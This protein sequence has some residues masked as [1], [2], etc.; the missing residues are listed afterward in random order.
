MPRVVRGRPTGR[1]KL[2]II[3]FVSGVFL[4]FP[5]AAAV[6]RAAVTSLMAGLGPTRIVAPPRMSQPRL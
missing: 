5:S 1:C 6:S 3:K 2:R 4:L